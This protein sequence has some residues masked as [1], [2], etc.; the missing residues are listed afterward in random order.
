[1]LATAVAN[2]IQHSLDRESQL[3]F[4]VIYLH[5]TVILSFAIGYFHL[6]IPIASKTANSHFLPFML[7]GQELK[8]DH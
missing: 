2:Y 6:D 8:L 1:M 5:P 3:E 4:P 7:P